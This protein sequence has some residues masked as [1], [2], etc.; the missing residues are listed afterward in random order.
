M[1]AFP[2]RSI[3]VVGG[4]TTGWLAA[5][6]LAHVLGSSCP[7]RLVSLPGEPADAGAVVSVPSLH[8]LLRLLKIDEIALMRA[9][10]A[11][12]RL[13]AMFRDWAAAGDAYFNG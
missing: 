11:T 7:V 12:Y 1:P 5:T 13:G 2:L 10:D 4:G 3:V 8:R 9:T 6:T